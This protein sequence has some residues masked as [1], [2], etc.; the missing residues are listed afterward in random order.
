[1]VNTLVQQVPALMNTL[2]APLSPGRKEQLRDLLHSK[3]IP[4]SSLAGDNTVVRKV[5]KIKRRLQK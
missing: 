5:V 2:V 3:R 1:V 4:V